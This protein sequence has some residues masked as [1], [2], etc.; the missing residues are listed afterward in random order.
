MSKHDPSLHLTTSTF[1][2]FQALWSMERRSP[3]KKV[4]N[5]QPYHLCKF[6]ALIWFKPPPNPELSPSPVSSSQEWTLDEKF[7]MVKKAGFDGIGI[8]Y[9]TSELGDMSRANPNLPS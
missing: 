1:E 4:P 7:S 8:E 6:R 5:T 2:V 3:D 9:G